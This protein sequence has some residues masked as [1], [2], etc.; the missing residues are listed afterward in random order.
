[1][2]NLIT[3]KK[4]LI[5]VMSGLAICCG[6]TLNAQTI[7][8]PSVPSAPSLGQ[9]YQELIGKAESYNEYKVIKN[10]VLSQYNKAV[11]DTIA[12]S[13]TT[14]LSLENMVN[15]QANQINQH[16]SKITSLENQLAESEKLRNSLT[17]LG[18]PLG[19]RFYHTIVWLII[20]GLAVFSTFA[21]TSF[22]RGNIV[23]KK[24]AKDKEIIEIQFEEHRK[25]AHE[26]QLKMARELQ[27]ERNLVEE[28]KAKMKSGPGSK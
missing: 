28:L 10:S 16:S 19:K 23:A 11:Q 3:M 24:T 6:L 22:V 8:Q 17:F 21:Y 25:T 14:I 26:K 20:A 12:L 18:I 4:T 2:T 9:Q 1:M 13:K 7:N 15:E 5:I 27:T